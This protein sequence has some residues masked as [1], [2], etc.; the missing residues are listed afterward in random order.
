MKSIHQYAADGSWKTA[1][2]L[3]HMADPF[4]GDRHGG[5]E[6][7]MEAV[8]ALLR[9]QE[10]LA[11]KATGYGHNE[12]ALSDPED[13]AAAASSGAG[14]GGRG[15]GGKGGKKGPKKD[16]EAAASEKK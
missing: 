4:V 13:G 9:T 1:W 16:S 3:T 10:D 7:E 6:C 12:P 5:T 15:R 14:G 11:R 2:P 8:L